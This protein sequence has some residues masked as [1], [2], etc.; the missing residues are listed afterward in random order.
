MEK[1]KNL[2]YI[3]LAFV[4]G[5][6][7]MYLFNN[8]K[9]EKKNTSENTEISKQKNKINF[10]KLMNGLSDAQRYAP[11]LGNMLQKASIGPAEVDEAI[12]NK[13][14]YQRQL[15]DTKALENIA[16][17]EAY[18]TNQ[19]LAQSGLTGN[20][21]LSAMMGSQL[22]RTKAISDAYQQVNQHNINENKLA[23]QVKQQNESDYINDSRYV[24]ETNAQNRA[25][26]D[27]QISK[28]NS[29]I[30]NSLG[31][32]GKEK[33]YEK[34]A[35]KLTG[36][37]KHGE[38]LSNNPEYK[39]QFDEIDNDKKLTL[40]E[41]YAKKSLIAKGYKGPTEEDIAKEVQQ[42]NLLM[43]YGHKAYGGYI[44]PKFKKY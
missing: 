10:N 37:N 28:F 36:Y 11:I 6:L 35:E 14:Q 34:M 1:N 9:I 17:Q 5:L 15:M 43:T 3:V 4:A 25:N 31:E 26:R 40:A 33:T 2:I 18:N 44:S 39:S 29:E 19:V 22:N 7:L 16:S 30:Y 21:L 41:K 42:Q 24:R 38:F 27:T 20:Q 32:I 13:Y 8:Y 23:E 12:K